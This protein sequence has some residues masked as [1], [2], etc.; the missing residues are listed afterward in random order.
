MHLN[1]FK[2]G[3]TVGWYYSWMRH[4]LPSVQTIKTKHQQIEQTLF[5]DKIIK[6][7]ILLVIQLMY[8]RSYRSKEIVGWLSFP[9]EDQEDAFKCLTLR[10]LLTFR[11]K[12]TSTP[13]SFAFLSTSCIFVT[14]NRNN[15]Q[16]PPPNLSH[17]WPLP[18]TLS[19]TILF[20]NPQGQK[21]RDT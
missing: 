1:I 11:R 17:F 5:K 3:I 10:F 4:Y 6:H 14:K 19:L 18:L 7:K 12:C 20:A 16:C 8:V 21:H 9:M 2:Y 15:P 13:L